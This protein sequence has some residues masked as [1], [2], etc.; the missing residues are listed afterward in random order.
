MPADRSREIRFGLVLYGGVSLAIYIN[1]VSH[2]FFRAVRGDGPYRF[3]KTLVDSSIVVDIIS[4]TSAGGINGIF[5]SYAL[6]NGKDFGSMAHLWREH[7]DISKLL[8][9]VDTAPEDCDSLLDSEGYYHRKLQ[10]A[11]DSM[12]DCCGRSDYEP[13]QQELDLFVTGTNIDGNVYTVIDDDGHLID[14]KD[15]RSVFCLKH[16]QRRKTPFNPSVDPLITQSLSKLARITSCFPGAFAPVQMTSGHKFSDEPDPTVDGH[17]REWGDWT[18]EAYFLDGGVLVNKP[19]TYTIESIF[20]RSA[21]VPVVRHLCYVEPDPDSFPTQAV[22]KPNFLSA[23]LN[24]AVGIKS[25]ESIADD[26]KSISDH[27][28]QVDRYWQVCRNLRGALPTWPYDLDTGY[29]AVVLPTEDFLFAVHNLPDLNCVGKGKQTLTG[30]SSV[31]G[32]F[33]ISQR[34]QYIRSRFAGLG[35]RA[36]KGLF[37]DSTSGNPAPID[38]PRDRKRATE[39][40]TELINLEPVGD[41]LTDEESLFRFDIYFRLRRLHHVVYRIA[42]AIKNETGNQKHIQSWRLLWRRLNHHIDIAEIVR[43]RMEYIMDRGQIDWTDSRPSRDVWADLRSCLEDLLVVDE[44]APLPKFPNSELDL[45]DFR[46]LMRDRAVKICNKQKG[47]SKGKLRQKFSGL[48]DQMDRAARLEFDSRRQQPEIR[49]FSDEFCGFV[50]LDAL[51]YPLELVSNLRG[52]DVIEILRISPRDAQTGF[53]KRNIREKIAGKTLNHFGGFFKRSWR[54][55]DILWGRLDSLCEI[56]ENTLTKDRLSEIRQKLFLRSKVVSELNVPDFHIGQIFRYSPPQT[57]DQVRVWIDKLLNGSD[58]EHQEALKRLERMR[59]LIIEMAQLEVLY[60]SVPEVIADAAR[61]QVA[62]NQYAVPLSE[63]GFVEDDAEVIRKA[64]AFLRLYQCSEQAIDLA[65]IRRLCTNLAHWTC[66]DAVRIEALWRAIRPSPHIMMWWDSQHDSSGRTNGENLIDESIRASYEE[67]NAKLKPGAAFL[68]TRGFVDPTIASL[69]A[70]QYAR[71]SINYLT[72]TQPTDAPYD[73]PMGTFFRQKYSV[74]SESVLS[75][76]PWLILLGIL[77]RAGLVLRNCV[78][79]SL[80]IEVRRKIRRHLLF[81]IGFDYPMRFVY[82]TVQFA[83]QQ[84]SALLAIYS[85]VFALLITLIAVGWF[86]RYSLLV[87]NGRAVWMNFFYLIIAPLF[88][89]YILSRISEFLGNKSMALILNTFAI[90]AG[91]L[92]AFWFFAKLTGVL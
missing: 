26:L 80:P 77:A 67:L 55:N 85:G 7:G 28:S 20:R 58:Q 46:V 89:L 50:A 81:R 24:G 37:M 44:N 51:V 83:R 27:N 41:V 75:G 4:G 1:G 68:P 21:N 62:W 32:F 11:F 74:G 63:S 71:A 22:S 92:N 10:E 9:R 72:P 43:F 54:S 25:Y 6:L 69:A 86:E 38:D 30:Q 91:V 31:P 5:L 15:H 34:E 19:F 82:W 59:A 87:V 84:P 2:E 17:L 66:Q 76:I 45:E 12:A 8:H 35:S 65:N 48:L 52:K 16:R 70:Q 29:N 60:E 61:E 14:V 36:L 39:L 47:T 18:N 90:F 79:E 78:L 23:T 56:F 49:C 42:E 33:P 88:A 13:E 64:Q 57:I 3:L 73:S 40:V 53:S